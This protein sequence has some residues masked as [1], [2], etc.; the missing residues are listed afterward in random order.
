MGL[1][2][3]ASARFAQ[4]DLFGNITA[5]RVI[6]EKRLRSRVLFGETA[7]K[8]YLQAQCDQI[9]IS[10]EIPYGTD[11]ARLER[12]KITADELYFCLQS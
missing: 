12:H 6:G 8:L 10:Q 1:F 9:S 3:E 7:G 4:S 11:S 2:V 5:A